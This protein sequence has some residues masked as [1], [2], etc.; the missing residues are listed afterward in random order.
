MRTPIY[1]LHAKLGAR[2]VDFAGYDM[3]VMF[4]SILEEH[5]AVRNAAGVFDVSHMSNVWLRG[6]DAAAALGKTMMCDATKVP[7]GGT[8]YTA[9]LRDDGTIID[10]L[11]VFRPTEKDYHIVP[12]A[13]MNKEVC[14]WISS[15]TGTRVEDV[16][17]ETCIIAFQGPKA[18]DMMGRVSGY[19]PALIKPF[20]CVDAPRLG[21]GAFI[22]R[23]GYTGE[24]GFE[25]FVP[26]GS[27][28][29]IVERIL[30][31]GKSHGV[32]PCGLGA[33]DTLRLEKGYCLAGHEFAAG[34]TP[35]QAGL[36]RFVNWDHDFIG[37]K[38]LERQ[39]AALPNR[40]VGVKVS[41]RGIPRQGC[42]IVAGGKVIGTLTSGT[43]SPTLKV[44]I[45]L[46]YVP[47]QHT[48]RGT[49]VDVMIRDSAV[50]AEIAEI[51]FL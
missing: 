51:P 26:A 15:K 3:P 18:K 23:T 48:A 6:P 38:A 1:P 4:T 35:L 13:G 9:V 42:K 41:G 19:D 17:T 25:L 20:R 43:M 5:E 28:I 10:D 2:F 30:E 7:V 45:G 33:R 22:S 27:G 11:Y 16:T 37:R 44:G 34:V 46:G 50:P 14:D 40:L 32:R 49:K 8:K 36:D 12:N 39:K 31:A 21:K 24:D 47:P 29:G